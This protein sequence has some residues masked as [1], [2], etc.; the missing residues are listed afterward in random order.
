MT[1]NGQLSSLVEQTIKT[2]G[3]ILI[4]I[5]FSENKQKKKT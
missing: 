3:K 4:Q 5:D 1:Q 2:I